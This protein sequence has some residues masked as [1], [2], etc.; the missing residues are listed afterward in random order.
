MRRFSQSAV[1]DLEMKLRFTLYG[2]TN[3]DR[4][5]ATRILST[6]LSTV[7]NKA[8]SV[9]HLLQRLMNFL[10][11]NFLIPLYRKGRLPVRPRHPVGYPLIS[12]GRS[13]FRAAALRQCDSDT[14]FP[15]CRDS[16]RPPAVEICRWDS[17]QPCSLD[18][19]QQGFAASSNSA[20]ILP[21]SPAPMILGHKVSG[22]QAPHAEATGD[23]S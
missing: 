23:S 22:F 2:H 11:Q 21:E 20:A 8:G 18:P 4:N 9:E 10:D 6:S 15:C 14:S 19:V 3:S 12:D 7:E 5:I 17:L 1:G 13:A 16:V